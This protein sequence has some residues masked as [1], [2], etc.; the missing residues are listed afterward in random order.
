MAPPIVTTNEGD[1][2][3]APEISMQRTRWA[4]RKMT[5]KSSSLKRLSLKGR[6]HNR[7]QSLAAEKKRASGGSGSS[8]PAG[9][10]PGQGQEGDDASNSQDVEGG[11]APR[12]L[13]FGLPLPKELQDE[14]GKPFQQY[15]RN[16]IRTAKYTPLSFIPKNLFFQFQNVANIF[17][18]FLVILV[19]SRIA[20]ISVPSHPSPCWDPRPPSKLTST[21]RRYSPSSVVSTPD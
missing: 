13:Y 5:I 3:N 20:T 12:K 16:K 19:V 15:P 10:A 14:E 1:N 9:D 2:D 17:F 18:L 7:T 11:A 21:A 4:T 8:Q 6:A